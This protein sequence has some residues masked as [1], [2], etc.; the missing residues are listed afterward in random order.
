MKLFCFLPKKPL[1]QIVTKYPALFE[2]AIGGIVCG[3]TYI[4]F[5]IRTKQNQGIADYFKGRIEPSEAIYEKKLSKINL[6]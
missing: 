6:N 1:I 5:I 4:T 2:T 3:P